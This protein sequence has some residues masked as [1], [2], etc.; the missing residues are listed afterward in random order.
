MGKSHFLFMSAHLDDAIISCGDYMCW[1]V[2]EGNAVTIATVF[3]AENS[4][5]SL[6]W[7]A[8][9]LHKKFNIG[10]QVMYVRR[11]EDLS[12]AN[13]LGADCI[14]L[15]VEECIYR[16]KP[17]GTPHYQKLEELFRVDLKSELSVIREVT[18]RMIAQLD[19][20]KYAQVYIPLGIGRHVD[21]CITRR[22]AEV[23]LDSV[24]GTTSSKLAYYED[25]P[26][27]SYGFDQDWRADLACGFSVNRIRLSKNHLKAKIRAI[28]LYKSQQRLL[29]S[30]RF[31]MF[32]QMLGASLGF[33]QH[34]PC[35]GFNLYTSYNPVSLTSK[36]SGTINDNSPQ[37][38]K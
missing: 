38:F 35:Y 13:S 29:W 1:L 33:D 23:W 3:T 10:S 12:A 8:K 19:L 15:N 11:R 2:Q 28:E 6:S 16:R 31:T 26:Y 7:L 37:F 27:K 22:A 4:H 18:T 32:K 24:H 5:P 25:L 34:Q 20:D 36:E 17:D 9:I 30:S 14:H 21:H